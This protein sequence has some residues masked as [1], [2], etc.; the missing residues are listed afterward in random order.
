MAGE[1]E[2][3]AVDGRA[4]LAAIKLLSWT[5]QKGVYASFDSPTTFR[6]NIRGCVFHVWAT[7]RRS[8]LETAMS[9]LIAHRPPS[10]LVGGMRSLTVLDS[11]V[12]LRL[13][14]YSRRKR[15]QLFRTA[16]KRNASVLGIQPDGEDLSHRI[17]PENPRRWNR[18]ELRDQDQRPSARTTQGARRSLAH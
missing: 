1:E 14:P 8:R 12:L 5:W 16:R 6:S 10:A 7:G 11:A 4:H 2:R 18:Q 3:T 9:L 13:A 15:V 17:E